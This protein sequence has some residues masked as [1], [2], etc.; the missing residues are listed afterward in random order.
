M[1]IDTPAIMIAAPKSSSGKTVFTCG[2]LSALQDMEIKPSVFKCGP[3]YVDP[4]FH[5]SVFSVNSANLDMFFLDENSLKN[6]YYEKSRNSQIN[7][8]EGAMGFY[9]GMGGI[10][11]ENSAYA[12]SKVLGVPVVLIID[13]KGSSLSVCAL[14]KGFMEFEKDN[15]ICGVILNRCSK[16]LF[17][18]LA[19]IIFKNNGIPALGYI[20]TE[21]SLYIENRQLG[22]SFNKEKFKKQA[23][24]ISKIIKETV[25]I[26]NLLKLAKKSQKIE[27]DREN[28][29]KKNYSLN[30]SVAKDDAFYFYYSENIEFLEKAGAKITY[31]SPINDEHIPKKTD[32]IYFGGG[33]PELFSRQLSENKGIKSEILSFYNNGGHIFAE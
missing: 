1:T 7:I 31:F 5:K 8:I 15:N 21:A 17:L 2:L 23:E 30:I 32:L 6:L 16:A 18:T 33:Y 20:P 12:I 26:A 25:D 28:I 22:L 10:S 19:P 29:F 13:I 4:L 27:F 3:D 14:I 11:D 24:K 9:D